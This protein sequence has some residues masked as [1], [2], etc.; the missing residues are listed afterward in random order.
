MPVLALGPGAERFRGVIDNT[1]VFR[2]YTDLT[3]IDHRN[4]SAPLLAHHDAG[5]VENAAQYARA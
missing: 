4:P 2:A 5:D 3:G 1:D